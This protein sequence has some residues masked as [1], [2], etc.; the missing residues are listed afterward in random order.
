MRTLISNCALVDIK[1]AAVRP[2][3]SIMIEAGRIL[4]VAPAG[5]EE[6]GADLV[7]NGTGTFA[8][9]GLID[10]HV[11]ID[12]DPAPPTPAG[13]T[14]G[15]LDRILIGFRAARNL[16]EAAASGVTS[17]RD[18]GGAHGVT[19]AVKEGWRRGE[20]I[21]A[22]PFVAG[23]MITA[24]GGHGAERGDGLG[25]EVC[26]PQET[27]R[28]VR[29]LIARGADVIK[30]VT[31]GAIARTELTP[32]E[33]DAAIDE[34]HW[35]GVTVAS[36]AN[37]SLRG[38]HNSIAAGCDSVEHCCVPDKRALEAMAEKHVAMCPTIAVL[39]RIKTN[40]ELYGGD[41]SKLYLAVAGVWEKHLENV[42]LAHTMGIPILAGSDAGMTGVRFDAVLEEVE[43]LV[44]C[45]LTTA[46]ALAAATTSAAEFLRCDDLG[47]IKA[48]GTADLVL[49][50]S[51]PLQDIR[52]LGDRYMVICSGHVIAHAEAPPSASERHVPC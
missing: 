18:L 23:Q 19:F 41:S 25:F 31:G 22:R 43:W 12:H 10:M 40:P 29:E 24:V 38:I 20:F 7:I 47:Q 49:L 48:G 35:N 1:A 34:A 36:H 6:D 21:G 30:V 27:R 9:P 26:G 2:G 13:S 39:S 32:E 8:I 5:E 14:G 15:N 45:G 16:R 44:H 11:H 4:R 46:Q 52:A 3:Q 51:D 50:N 37:F 42:Y 17:V 33:L 28:A